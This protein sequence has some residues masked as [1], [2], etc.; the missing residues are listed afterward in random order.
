MSNEKPF[1]LL[2]WAESTPEKFDMEAEF[3]ARVQPLMTQ[4]HDICRELGIPYNCRFVL[5]IRDGGHASSTSRYI[6][7][8][9]RATPDMLAMS[10]MEHFNDEYLEH[11]SGLREA[12]VAKFNK[13]DP[14]GVLVP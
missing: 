5:S 9:E 3:E 8:P 11:L 4:A 2:Q 14:E 1:T 13:L 7:N 12:C 6:P 10:M